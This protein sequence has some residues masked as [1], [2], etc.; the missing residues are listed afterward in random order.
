MFRIFYAESDATLYE[1]KPD[2]NT[3]LDEILEIGKRIHTD[4]ETSKKI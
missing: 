4:G 2:S 1:H 3:G